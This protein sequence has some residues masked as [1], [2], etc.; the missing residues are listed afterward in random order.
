[1][2]VQNYTLPSDALEADGLLLFTYEDHAPMNSQ[3]ENLLSAVQ[4]LLEAHQ[5]LKRSHREL[6]DQL[7]AVSKELNQR[8]QEIRALDKP[9]T[10]SP[11]SSALTAA[12]LDALVE[13]IDNCIALLKT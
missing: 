8:E 2:L 1:M 10:T 7:E 12:E 9:S 11:Q 3:L 6:E 13:E 4:Q 5:A